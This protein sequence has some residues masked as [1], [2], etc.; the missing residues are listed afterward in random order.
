[1]VAGGDVEGFHELVVSTRKDWGRWRLSVFTRLGLFRVGAPNR[2]D[3]IRES[4]PFRLSRTHYNLLN[5]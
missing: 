4:E 2:G 1:M 3:M 5:H